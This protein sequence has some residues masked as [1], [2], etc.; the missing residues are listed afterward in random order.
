MPGTQENVIRVHVL[1]RLI[2]RLFSRTVGSADGFEGRIGYVFRDTSLLDHALSHRS[3]A[4]AVSNSNLMSNERLE[5]LGDAVLGLVASNFLFSRYPD[6]EEGELSRIRSLL[7][8]RKALKE[9]AD[10]I[11]LG[12][13]LKLSRSEEKTGGRTRFSINS[14]TFEALI[15][16]IYL[17]GGYAAA[18][19]FIKKHVLVMLDRM[20]TDEDY[21]NFKSRL[22]EFVQ[23]RGNEIPQYE[24]TSES[25]PDHAKTFDISV[26]FWG[27]HF[28]AGQGKSKKEAEQAA[29]RSALDFLE[30]N[31]DIKSEK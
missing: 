26:K 2:G 21:S 24:V 14:N 25:G 28:G 19:T 8:S 30:K 18:E 13:Q 27:K 5:F 9:A 4:F 17:D 12:D 11:N 29:A 10:R 1:K 20:L 7:I 16:A 23:A 22:L 3:Y 31:P 6:K 15:A